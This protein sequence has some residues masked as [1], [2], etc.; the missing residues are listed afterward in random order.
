MCNF[1]IC[2]LIMEFK[3]VIFV[4]YFIN[5]FNIYSSLCTFVKNTRLKNGKNICTVLSIDIHTITIDYY[6]QPR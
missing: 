1:E 5:N 6:L 2:D 3:P 4:K